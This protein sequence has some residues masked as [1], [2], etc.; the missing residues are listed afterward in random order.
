MLDMGLTWVSHKHTADRLWTHPGTPGRRPQTRAGRSKQ[1]PSRP[2]SCR[3]LVGERRSRDFLPGSDRPDGAPLRDETQDKLE[4]SDRGK[5]VE[6]EQIE[7]FETGGQM[8]PRTGT[9]R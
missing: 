7:Q 1:T 3:T 4:Q 6:R 8:D 5:R 2:C 9:H